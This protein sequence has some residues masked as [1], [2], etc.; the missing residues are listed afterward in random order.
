VHDEG[1]PPASVRRHRGICP[2]RVRLVPDIGRLVDQIRQAFQLSERSLNKYL[3]L[4]TS[5]A[6]KRYLN[7]LEEW[8]EVEL[9]PE[10]KTTKP[11]IKLGRHDKDVENQA[12]LLLEGEY[13]RCWAVL[14]RE[15]EDYLLRAEECCSFDPAV[16]SCGRL[17][18]A[19]V[20]N[21]FEYLAWV[22][23]HFE[24]MPAVIDCGI[25]R[26]DCQALLAALRPRV[27]GLLAQVRLLAPEI[28]VAEEE[29][30]RDWL[31]AS[32]M[33]LKRGS[34]LNLNEFVAQEKSIKR[35]GKTLP[36]KK[37]RIEYVKAV[38]QYLASLRL[39]F[40]RNDKELLTSCDVLEKTLLLAEEHSHRNTKRFTSEIVEVLLPELEKNAME[41]E[42]QILEVK[43]LSAETDPRAALAQLLELHAEIEKLKALESEYS[44]YME[45]LCLPPAPNKSLDHLLAEIQARRAMWEFFGRW[46]EF[47]AALLEAPLRDI[48][49]EQLARISAFEEGLRDIARRIV[50]N[51][52]IQSLRERLARAASNMRLIRALSYGH[53]GP[54]HQQEI[55]AVIAPQSIQELTGEGVLFRRLVECRIEERT[56]EIEL[57]VLQAE[58]EQELEEKVT[59]IRKSWRELH[60]KTTVHKI[61]SGKTHKD[62]P[63]LEETNDSIELFNSMLI[64]L[65]SVIRSKYGRWIRKEAE[66]QQALISQALAYLEDWSLLQEDWIR[67]ES[68]FISGD[69]RQKIAE[70]GLLE[71][72]DKQYKGLMKSANKYRTVKKLLDP[73]FES[74]KI[75]AKL[76]ELV[77]RIYRALGSVIDYKRKQFPRFFYL[78]DHEML[79]L[80]SKA[81]EPEALEPFFCKCFEGLKRLCIDEATRNIHGVVSV[82]EEEMRFS[83][84]G[85]AIQTK[86][87]IEEWSQ[88]LEEVVTDSL[89]K[90]INGC[91][92]KSD[93]EVGRPAWASAHPTQCVLVVNAIDFNSETCTC[94]ADDSPGRSLEEW[95]HILALELEQSCQA[96]ARLEGPRLLN[97]YCYLQQC[98][99]Q[100]DILHRLRLHRVAHPQDYHW[101][102]V[103]K[104][105]W[106][107]LEE[108]VVC[109]ALDFEARY[110]YEFGMY[111][112]CPLYLDC[113]LLLSP[114]EIGKTHLLEEFAQ[115][116]AVMAKFIPC[117]LNSSLA[118][119][120]QVMAGLLANGHWGCLLHLDRLAQETMVAV[121][122]E[123]ARVQQLVRAGPDEV[124]LA[125]M[126]L[127]PKPGFNVFITLAA[128]H[129]PCHAMAQFRTAWVPLPDLEFL[130]CEL[131]RA[132]LVEQPGK[133]AR[134]LALL[135]RLSQAKIGLLFRIDK[136]GFSFYRL[137]KYKVLNQRIPFSDDI[138]A[139]TITVLAGPFLSETE[140][141]E[142]SRLCLLVTGLQTKWQDDALVKLEESLKF[143]KLHVIAA[144]LSSKTYYLKKLSE[145]L[146]RSMVRIFPNAFDRGRLFRLP[147]NILQGMFAAEWIVFDG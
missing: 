48:S 26:V 70:A 17:Q 147:E 47:E 139:E 142:F 96:G 71:E 107:E 121:A 109:R 117:S 94:L 21:L 32:T 41:I 144:P 133:I 11:L 99:G 124:V 35:I 93:S 118:V 69:N 53:L 38:S 6:L 65:N 114:L 91:R 1:S 64:A 18:E 111:G 68:I 104:F 145:K 36:H 136:L 126:A 25:L 19:M 5:P 85:G 22:S 97:Y 106:A 86:S 83:V 122:S 123:V 44:Q 92:H 33:A 10:D 50:Q 74:V 7:V 66:E 56:P 4:K 120:S 84:R 125:G 82:K 46:G 90:A 80:L 23:G 42:N 40:K 119:I 13:Q 55:N 63:V 128:D 60:L 81:A 98:I 116:L 103:L 45:E 14:Q 72:A 134:R 77:E 130:L 28:V 52:V 129:R 57:I 59:S 140:R 30:L 141:A 76:R 27:D 100:L 29:M 138:L 2:R 15:F 75:L 12:L 112:A 16:L 67:I 105:E 132:L 9:K 95:E 89:K 73:A 102:K 146:G 43:F 61:F 39:E 54:R 127:A 8:E 137:L 37:R 131:F 31:D 88:N 24:F 110:G 78:S 49:G 51:L 34:V 101:Q 115:T 3:K 113:Q 108:A 143:R 62:L 20:S 79:E 87:D 58:K 135:F